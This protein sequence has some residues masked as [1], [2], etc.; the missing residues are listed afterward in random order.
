MKRV[1]LST[2]H[3]GRS[4]WRLIGSIAAFALAFFFAACGDDDSGS[5]VE[6]VPEDSSSSI[7]EESSS[8][9]KDES[10]S[11]SV[12]DVILSSSEGSSPSS[13]SSV[14]SSSSKKGDPGT[15][16]SEKSSSSAKSSSSV[17]SS[18]SAKSSSSSVKSSSS[19]VLSSSTIDLGSEY[20]DVAKTLKDLRDNQIYRTATIGTQTWMAENL[21]FETEKSFCYDDVS[22]N[23]AKYGR[24]YTWAEAMDSVGTWSMNGKGCGYTVM[25]SPTYPVRGVCPKGWHLPTKEEWDTLF[26]AVGGS[27]VVAKELKSTNG[28]SGNGNGLD[29]YA[30]SALPGGYKVDDNSSLNYEDEGDYAYFW[31]STEKAKNNYSAY[32]LYLRYNDDAYV[33]S[34]YKCRL[35]SVRC[36]KD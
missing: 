12:K 14:K 8:S 24:L 17:A 13:S 34:G 16:S 5:F 9:V 15:S 29:T 4:R 35:N 6:P 11:S 2:R 33:S 26:T 23:C 27:D 3:P 22:R 10:S 18:S 31:S 1:I 32:Y 19:V 30:F 21:N 25:C 20:D 36:V 7:G 28:W